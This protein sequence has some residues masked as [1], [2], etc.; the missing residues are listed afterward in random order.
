MRENE[1]RKKEIKQDTM[2]ENEK[3]VKRGRNKV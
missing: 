1:R 2:R 3:E